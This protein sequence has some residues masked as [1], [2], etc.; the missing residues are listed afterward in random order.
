LQL[1]W[2]SDGRSV[3]DVYVAGKLVI[4]EGRV[5]GVDVADLA[6]RAASAGR[7]LRERAGIDQAARWPL[8]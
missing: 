4:D 8:R 7:A 1:V 5:L 2:G 6:I 3:R